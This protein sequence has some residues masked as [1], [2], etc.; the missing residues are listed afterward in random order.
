MLTTISSKPPSLDLPVSAEN[1]DMNDMYLVTLI[2]KVTDWGDEK[3]AESSRFVKHGR[4]GLIEAVE[5]VDW[6]VS[7]GHAVEGFVE[8]INSNETRTLVYR[9]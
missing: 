2:Q 8:R 1:D 3:T 6:D 9:R 4:E 7:N 5:A